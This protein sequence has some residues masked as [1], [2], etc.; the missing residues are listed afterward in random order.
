[1]EADGWELATGD[2]EIQ[3]S[4]GEQEKRS[5]QPRRPSKE[6][7]LGHSPCLPLVSALNGDH[8]C[9]DFAPVYRDGIPGNGGGVNSPGGP[10]GA[11]GTGRPSCGVQRAPLAHRHPQSIKNGSA[12]CLTGTE[13]VSAP[14]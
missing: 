9:P 1:M 8:V 11:G 6:V 14:E 3:R 4:R 12:F 2:R 13:G 5:S 10:E 7:T